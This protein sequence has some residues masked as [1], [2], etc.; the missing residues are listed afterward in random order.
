MSSA[1]AIVI[2]CSGL[3]LL[4]SGIVLLARSWLMPG[5]SAIVTINGRQQLTAAAGERLLWV[6]AGQGVLLP[7]ACGGRGSCGQCR[8]QVTRGG[9]AIL[10]VESAMISRREAAAGARLAC[11][12][13]VRQDLA[14]AVPDSV[15]E[16]Q[17]CVGIV[18]SNQSITT[19]LKELTIRLP[20]SASFQ[21]AA[22]DYVVIEAPAGTTTFGQFDI[23]EPYRKAWDQKD[24]WN[25]AVKR[26]APATRAY[27]M[28][29]APSPDGKL[30]FVIRIA[31]PPPGARRRA[32]PGQVSSF[33]FGLQ[34]GQELTIA[35]PFGD[36]HVRDS[37]AEMVFVGGGAG[38]APLRAMIVDQL[39]NRKSNR[40]I[41]LWYG[42]RDAGEIC[43]RAEL[44]ELARRYANFS[45]FA[46]LSDLHVTPDWEGYRGFVHAVLRD[47]YMEAHPSP[48]ELEF[49]LCGPPLMSGAVTAMLE[50]FGV[51]PDNILF[52]DFGS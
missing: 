22:G 51:P 47:Q 41:S 33:L 7:A 52:D 48:E 9:G 39:E 16:A 46:A 20:E 50:D 19:F 25:M 11:M 5:G 17:R 31:L 37:Q 32:P 45:W 14:I 34:E 44:D 24:L 2:V 6:L 30:Q 29:N 4:L 18:E 15:L 35:G 42:A 8:V 13:T 49:Y 3:V 38:I 43:Y 27:S 40:R 23:A 26:R 12:V 36:F 28:A 10:P 21:F 1:V